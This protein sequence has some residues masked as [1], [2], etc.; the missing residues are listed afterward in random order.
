MVAMSGMCFAA[1]HREIPT[2]P[3]AD[4]LGAEVDINHP[5][6]GTRRLPHICGIVCEVKEYQFFYHQQPKVNTQLNQV[7][8]LYV[9]K[10]EKALG[11]AFMAAVIL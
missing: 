6:K 1:C 2:G 8:E 4:R 10:G 9:A 11:E 3:N 5:Y 7:Y